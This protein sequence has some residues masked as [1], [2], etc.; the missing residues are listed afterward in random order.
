MERGAAAVRQASFFSPP[1][2]GGTSA[3]KMLGLS[4]SAIPVISRGERTALK[5]LPCSFSTV[6]REA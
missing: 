3:V 6:G 5:P 2:L 4:L 1:A